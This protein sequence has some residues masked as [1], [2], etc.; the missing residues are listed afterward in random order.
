MV[1]LNNLAHHPD[2]ETS[3]L[4]GKTCLEFGCGGLNPG[5][6]MFAMLL[7]GAHS[8]YAVDLDEVESVPLACRALYTIA[9]AAVMGVDGADIQGDPEEILAR[10][11]SFDLEKL[12]DGDPK[13][14]D[15]ER[16]RHI[17]APIEDA[18]IPPGSV[19]VVT[20]NSVYEHLADP[21]EIT[22]QLARL[23]RPGGLA[24]HA[25][26][27]F[28]HRTYANGQLHPLTFLH[29][30]TNEPLVHGCNRIRP[31]AFAEVFER[32][33]LEVRGVLKGAKLP[34]D[35]VEIAA[36]AAPYRDL[37]REHLEVARARFYLRKR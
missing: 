37:P 5:G 24:V 32:H 36:L 33:G 22:A 18:G 17:Q 26:D 4:K 30:E 14:L 1:A 7:Q 3:W 12:A 23:L 19:D 20:S 25:I 13:G 31:L 34:L 9:A 27:G 21:D 8:A 29:D 16:L 11:S 35:E 28:D 15:L 2:F 10:V 6:T